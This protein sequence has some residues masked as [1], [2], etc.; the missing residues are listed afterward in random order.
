MNVTFKIL[1]SVEIASNE[2]TKL[3][4]TRVQVEKRIPRMN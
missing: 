3:E 1:F 2:A 4:V